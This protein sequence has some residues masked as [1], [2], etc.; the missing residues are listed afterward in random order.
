M[1]ETKPQEFDVLIVGAGISGIGMACHLQMD[2]PGKSFAVLER[3]EAIGGTW[4]LFRYPGIRSDSDMFS[5][6]YSFRPWYGLDTLADGPS[7][8][9]YV[10]ETAR[11]YGVEDKIRFGLKIVRADWSSADSR[12]TLTALHE[13]TGETRRYR[14]RYL[15]LCTGYYR[16]D[17]GYMPDFPGIDRFRGQVI[18]PQHWPEDLDYAGKR[19]LVIGSGATAITL[20]P[21]MAEDAGHVTMLQ[22]SPSYIIS[23]PAFDRLSAL[24]Q[25]FLPKKWVFR[26]ARRRFIRLQRWHY[27][28]SRKYPNFMRR[29]LLRW[30]RKHLGEDFDPRHFTPDYDPWDQ[31]LCAVPDADLFEAIRKGKASIVTDRI[32][33]FTESGIRLRSGET[34]EA[35]IVISATGLDVTLLGDMEI[36]IDG[37]PQAPNEA[38][39]YKGVLIEDAPNLATIFGYTNAS[40]TLKVDIAAKYICRLL[41]HM[42]AKGYRVAVPR[43]E[44]GCKEDIPVMGELNSGYIRRASHR[45]PRQGSKFP[46]R[47]LNHYG[48]DKKILLKEPI[49]DGI[50]RFDDMPAASADRTRSAA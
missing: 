14:C 48:R 31:R 9:R 20:V 37:E 18:H 26:M 7:I 3:R 46:W 39:T 5:F 17:A 44:E 35:D 49:E 4:D 2:C 11:E 10:T 21:A 32:D 34:L 16:Y 38:M 28:L 43:D 13:P 25:R 41:N 36:A 29:L 33:T 8:R 47:T 24:M 12:W 40:W 19:V 22:R 50:L 30:V 15:V 45:L 1:Q 27:A 42:D 6:G 23:I